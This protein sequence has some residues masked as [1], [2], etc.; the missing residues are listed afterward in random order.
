MIVFRAENANSY[1]FRVFGKQIGRTALDIVYFRITTYRHPAR[2]ANNYT[3]TG[4]PFT[5]GAGFIENLLVS[6]A[7]VT[8]L[9]LD[10][11]PPSNYDVRVLFSMEYQIT[12]VRKRRTV[13]FSFNCVVAGVAML[14]SLSLGCATNWDKAKGHLRDPRKALLIIIFCQFIALPLVM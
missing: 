2:K 3:G 9:E 1:E 6:S 8:S 7:G 13:D 10:V 4:L 11:T 12:V 5:L 14:S